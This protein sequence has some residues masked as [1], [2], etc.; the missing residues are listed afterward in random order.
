[1]TVFVSIVVSMIE[2]KFKFKR[3]EHKY[4]FGIYLNRMLHLYKSH[5]V[6]PCSR[7]YEPNK[8][9]ECFAVVYDH[10]AHIKGL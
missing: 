6:S 2:T 5:A 9:C 8:S 4:I 7:Y 10:I 1:M 3:L